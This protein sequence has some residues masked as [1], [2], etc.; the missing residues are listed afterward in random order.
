MGGVYALRGICYTLPPPRTLDPG[1]RGPRSS[2]AGR[3]VLEG[4]G[5]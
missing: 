4:I 3:L 5:T 2:G 1:G